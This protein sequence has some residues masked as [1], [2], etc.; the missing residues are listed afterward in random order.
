MR[1]V[2]VLDLR[3][4]RLKLQRPSFRDW[5]RFVR[6]FRG[7]WVSQQSWSWTATE[8]RQQSRVLLVEALQLAGQ[9][10]HFFIVS[11]RRVDVDCVAF[12]PRLLFDGRTETAE[13][14][15]K[16]ILRYRVRPASK[17]LFEVHRC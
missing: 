17:S 10:R 11:L 4:S 5:S 13:Q 16:S 6:R 12:F 7:S 2:A 3:E 1:F 9:L 8:F 15:G 14:H